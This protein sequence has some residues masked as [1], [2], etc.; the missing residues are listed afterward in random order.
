MNDLVNKN[1]NETTEVKVTLEA[2]EHNA[3]RL[4]MINDH[5]YHQVGLHSRNVRNLE[6]S[7]S[8][9]WNAQA[10]YNQT[11]INEQ[12]KYDFYNHKAYSIINDTNKPNQPIRLWRSGNLY[13]YR[14]SPFSDLIVGK[15]EEIAKEISSIYGNINIVIVDDLNNALFTRPQS[16]YSSQLFQIDHTSK[17]K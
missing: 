13:Y 11:M 9:Y 17:S 16:K 5:M 2:Y 6:N 8:R 10:D 7:N 3:N 4:T 12:I 15:R 14:P 1:N